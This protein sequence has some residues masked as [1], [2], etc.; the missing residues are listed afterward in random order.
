M[1]EKSLAL[2]PRRS[3]VARLLAVA[4]ACFCLVSASRGDA[5][6]PGNSREMFRALGVGDTY[7]ER[8]TGGVAIDADEIDPLLRILYKL[9]QFPAF[10][11]ER[12]S[13]GAD[14]LG[15]TVSQP[16]KSRGGFYRL[17]GRV[18]AVEPQRPSRDQSQR[19]EM[20]RY[21]RCRIE[22]DSPR[23][24]ADVYSE[25]VP[26]A[27]QEGGKPDVPGGAF[28]AF[29]KLGK[30]SNGLDTL[31]FAAPRLAWY[32]N[33]LL[34]ELGMD[35][36]LLDDLQHAKNL[37]AEQR[38]AL[39]REAFYQLLAAVGRTRPRQLI[40]QADA[41]LANTPDRWRWKNRENQLQYS[42]VPL[43]NEPGTQ[44]GRLVA[45]SGAARRVVEIRV[46]DPETAARFGF[47]HYYSVSL[48]TDDSQGNPLT[49]CVRELPEGMPYGSDPRYGETVRV[50]GFFLKTW[51]YDVQKM[52][53]PALSP[54]PKTNAQ[55][56]PLLI[57][58][59]LVW[60]PAMKP[61][62][63][64]FSNAV[65]LLVLA[66]AMLLI[67][68]VAWRSRRREKRWVE[69]A[70]GEEPKL[71]SGVDL[72]RAEPDFGRIAEMDHGEGREKPE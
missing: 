26:V 22:L 59:S 5:Q 31:I 43:F 19:Y 12:W 34:G 25:N 60:Y 37:S 39:D 61:A 18:L 27:W 24:I 16:G 53:D 15:E 62:D 10:D 65:L 38:K 14:K 56:S 57:G 6:A 45:L 72:G 20:P 17:R 54:D 23:R 36:G 69:R 9:R 67:W 71:D 3:I 4:A 70:I 49:F 58:R 66:V 68:A 7:F 46:E 51:R 55:L 44:I 50:A 1:T 42:V 13:A 52:S 2:P 47:D 48:F 32:P 11:M 29:L 30:K 28:G 35:F 64:T 8:L 41:D 40:E 33:D 21:F 63:S